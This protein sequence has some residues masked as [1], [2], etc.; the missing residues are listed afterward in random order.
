LSKGGEDSWLLFES[1]RGL[2]AEKFGQCQCNEI[3]RITYAFVLWY[4]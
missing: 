1:M 4:V 3:W 2:W